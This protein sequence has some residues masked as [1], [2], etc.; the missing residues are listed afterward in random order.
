MKRVM[1]IQVEVGEENI[2]A[3]RGKFFD[4]DVGWYV[5]YPKKKM[6]SYFAGLKNAFKATL[7]TMVDS[8]EEKEFDISVS[9]YRVS[10]PMPTTLEG[11]WEFFTK[12]PEYSTLISKGSKEDYWIN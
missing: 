11:A 2:F 9:R 3:F 4:G 12:C 5:F 6:Y 7:A 8:D 1:M 10:L